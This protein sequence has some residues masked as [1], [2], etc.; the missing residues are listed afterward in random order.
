MN[1]VEVDERRISGGMSTA[2]S[3]NSRDTLSL[4][5]AGTQWPYRLS[6]LRWVGQ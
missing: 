6:S 2:I 1:V 3:S 5:I 4:G